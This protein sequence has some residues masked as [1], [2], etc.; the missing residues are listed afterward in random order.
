MSTT[1]AMRGIDDGL[2]VPEIAAYP[3][4]GASFLKM[5]RVDWAIQPARAALLVHDMQNY[6]VDRFAE[7]GVLLFNCAAILGAARAAGMP[8]VYSIARREPRPEQRGL[9]FDMW[10]AGMGGGRE[11]AGD[12]QIV[13]PLAKFDGEIVIVKRKI[14][15]FFR[16]DLEA[17]L[18]ERGV[19]QLIITGV[20]AHHGCLLSAADAYM[21]DIKPFFV[22]DATADHSEARHRATCD[23]IP[24]LCGQNV[25][26]DRVLAALAA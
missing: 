7:P 3:M 22:V 5:N 24:S 4:P 17:Q 14:S 20:Y 15:A 18:R 9:A 19:E 13:A 26:T 6:W 1:V 11:N 16:T 8:I 12:E 23:L 25:T 2:H 10:G 21:R